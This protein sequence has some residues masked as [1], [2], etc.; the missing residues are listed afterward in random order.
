MPPPAE[1]ETSATVQA[2]QTPQALLQLNL[3]PVQRTL[4]R[5]T[6]LLQAASDLNLQIVVALHSQSNRTA[7]RKKSVLFGII[8]LI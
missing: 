5:T 1:V 3:K 8:E 6:L 4:V 7:R 2:K